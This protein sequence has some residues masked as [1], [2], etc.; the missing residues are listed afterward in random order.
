GEV[1]SAGGPWEPPGAG[2]PPNPFAN[3]YAPP[4]PGYDAGPPGYPPQTAGYPLDYELNEEENRIVS[5]AALWARVLGIMLIIEGVVQLVQLNVIGGPLSIAI[6]AL[7]ISAAGSF[8]AVVNT[9]GNDIGNLVQA[10]SKVGSVFK[11]RVIL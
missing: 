9:Q 1:V 3:P 2:P 10:I 11:I 6:G 5:G 8:S 4:A 7:L